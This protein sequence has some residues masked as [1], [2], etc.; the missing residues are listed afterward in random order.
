MEAGADP[1]AV[2]LAGK[3]HMV[4]PDPSGRLC[5]GVFQGS[6]NGWQAWACTG[7]A[8]GRHHTDV[9]GD[10][11]LIYGV[12]AANQLWHSAVG[13]RLSS[14][15]NMIADGLRL[16]SAPLRADP[17]LIPRRLQTSSLFRDFHTTTTDWRRPAQSETTGVPCQPPRLRS[18]ASRRY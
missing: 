5:Y 11:V 3:I 13:R 17:L 6:G 4:A 10:R 15:N 9:V 16:T 1:Q 2:A 8:L 12:D 14:A 7:G 18:T